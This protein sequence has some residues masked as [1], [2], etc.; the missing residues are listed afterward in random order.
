M[1]V[2]ADGDII[3]NGFDRQGNIYPCGFYK[4]TGDQFSNKKFLM[5]CVE[6]LCGINILEANSKTVT[7]RPLDT[8]RIEKT[9]NYW[10]LL[11]LILPIAM[12][13]IFR[14]IFIYVRYRKYKSNE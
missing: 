6:Y 8:K 13:L 1:I 9:K 14:V 3:K 7:L 4:Y 2:V 12:I 5:N 10:K 11:N